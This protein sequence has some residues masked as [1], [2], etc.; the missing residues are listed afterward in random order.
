MVGAG[1]EPLKATDAH[2]VGARP[3]SPTPDDG[4]G[5]PEDYNWLGS[6]R[7]GGRWPSTK[8]WRR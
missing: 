6:T 3:A 4:L 7:S 2:I 5:P 1:P 8:G